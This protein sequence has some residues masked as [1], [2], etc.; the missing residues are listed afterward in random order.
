MDYG[1]DLD[2]VLNPSGSS[3]CDTLSPISYLNL[4]LICIIEQR[5]REI[6]EIC[7]KYGYLL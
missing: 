3:D 4:G 1:L 7:N 2:Y 5:L 6:I